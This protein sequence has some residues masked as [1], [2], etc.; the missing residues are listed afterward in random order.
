MK[1][2]FAL[3]MITLL[4]IIGWFFA[5]PYYTLYQLKNAYDSQDVTVINTHINFPS[6]QMDIKNQLTPVLVKKVQTITQS[7]FAKLLNVQVDETAMIEKLVKPAVINGITPDTL[8]TILTM[9]G[10]QSSLNNNTKLLGGLLAVAMDK[11]KLNPDTLIDLATAKT[12]DELNQKLLNQVTTSDLAKG[13][14]KSDN[15]PTANYCGINCFNIQT[16]VQG[17][18]LT[19]QMARKGFAG[20]EIV[21]VKLPI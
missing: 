21:G 16:Q 19:V 20:W 7:P 10:N 11:I 1:K 17:Y 14:G 5:S 2:I 12:T 18:P 3:I 4:G 9:Q 8:K 15:K 13:G 6:V